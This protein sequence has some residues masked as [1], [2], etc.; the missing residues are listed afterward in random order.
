M[1][2]IDLFNSATISRVDRL[3]VM[4]NAKKTLKSYPVV[5][6]IDK[7]TW[8]YDLYVEASDEDS[9]AGYFQIYDEFRSRYIYICTRKIGK[10]KK[11]LA[12]RDI[13]YELDLIGPQDVHPIM[14]TPNEINTFYNIVKSVVY[15]MVSTPHH[16]HLCVYC[17]SGRSRSPAFVAAYLV[18][19]ACYSQRQA[20]AMLS[21]RFV[22]NRGDMRGIDRDKRFVGYVKLLE[23]ELSSP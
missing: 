15:Q 13:T 9:D 11:F 16:G 2:N 17:C 22:E 19:V 3:T 7:S 1:D 14:M 8:D 18:T 5:R 20:Y 21:L 4:M 6:L 10:S 23:D 12:S